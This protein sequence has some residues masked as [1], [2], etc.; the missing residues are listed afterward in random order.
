LNYTTFFK[1]WSRVWQ[2]REKTAIHGMQSDSLQTER[3][4]QNPFTY[5]L[6][7]QTS[8]KLIE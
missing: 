5:K 6:I 4:C 3:E 8:K 2:Q 1:S 7:F